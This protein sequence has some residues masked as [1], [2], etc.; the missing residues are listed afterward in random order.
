MRVKP[1]KAPADPARP[2][3]CVLTTHG[4]G[5]APKAILP[6]SPAALAEVSLMPSSVQL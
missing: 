4:W 3:P 2:Q 5:G 6:T 1:R